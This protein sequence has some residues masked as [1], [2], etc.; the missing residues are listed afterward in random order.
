MNSVIVLLLFYNKSVFFLC[1]SVFGIAELLELYK[2]RH[3][4]LEDCESVKTL[5]PRV[6]NLITAMNSRTAMASMA[7]R[8]EAF[9]VCD[10]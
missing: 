6:K 1:V 5:Y 2:D 8:N 7:P 9:M 4:E 10:K 3:D